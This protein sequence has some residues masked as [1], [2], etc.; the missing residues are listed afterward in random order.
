M[1]NILTLIF[2][3]TI[4]YSCKKEKGLPMAYV[5]ASEYEKC[6]EL[7]LTK[8]DTSAYNTLSMDFFDSPNE[9][10]F[11]YTALIMANKYNYGRAYEDAYMC[12]T[13]AYHKKNYEELDNL[14]SETKKLALNLLLRGVKA[15][16]KDCKS[17]LGHQYIS[18]K[19]LPK[20]KVKG[21]KLIAES[22]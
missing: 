2:L 22:Y 18:G 7:A 10:V 3:T 17:I 16:S 9:G 6:K 1:K 8:G 11:L 19:H 20:D 21:E 4:L 14:D 15:N 12:L 13:D 5:S